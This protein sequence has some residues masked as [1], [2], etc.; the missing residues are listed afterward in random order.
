M[1][2]CALVV[3]ISNQCIAILDDE[4]TESN[5]KNRVFSAYQS[6]VHIYMESSNVDKSW[7]Q[8]FRESFEA[9]I[10]DRTVHEHAKVF[11]KYLRI[12]KYLRDSEALL[13][14]SIEMLSLYPTEYVPLDMICWLY[15][16]RF[17]GV[18][19]CVQDVCKSDAPA[20]KT[21][22]N[23]N[24]PI[25]RINFKDLNFTPSSIETYADKILQINDASVNALTAKGIHL[26]LTENYVSAR[27]Y[28]NRGK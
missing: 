16:E 4:V 3:K 5:D 28:L 8:L 1:R 10:N 12:L 15:V 20:S 27:D 24:S 23:F 14:Q 19:V 18:D 2:L 25:S 21:G 6:L 7:L 11:T 22:H 9:I 13:A 26:Y 17:K